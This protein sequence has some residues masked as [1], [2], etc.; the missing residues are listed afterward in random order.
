MSNHLTYNKIKLALIVMDKT[1]TGATSGENAIYSN[2][3]GFT[4]SGKRTEE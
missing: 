1:I 4:I 2:A 3:E